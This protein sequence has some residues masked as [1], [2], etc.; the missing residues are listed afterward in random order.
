MATLLLMLL[1]SALRIERAISGAVCVEGLGFLYYDDCVAAIN[2]VPMMGAGDFSPL[3][4]N[5]IYRVP[6][7]TASPNG[8]CIFSVE[9]PQTIGGSS[10]PIRAYGSDVRLAAYGIM[11]ACRSAVTSEHWSGGKTFG[12]GGWNTVGPSRALG[13]PEHGLRVV[14]RHQHSQEIPYRDP[15]SLPMPLR[16]GARFFTVQVKA[17]QKKEAAHDKARRITQNLSQKEESNVI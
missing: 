5:P 4:S 12:S 8:N 1:V 6:F 2:Q 3:A 11:T 14:L 15:V 7:K 17:N 9:W 16:G 10:E 13:G